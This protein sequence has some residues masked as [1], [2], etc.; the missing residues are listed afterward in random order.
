MAIKHIGVEVRISKRTMWVG[1]KVYPLAHVTRVEPLEIVPRRGRIVVRYARVAGAWLGLGILGLIV[2]TCAGN[3]VPPA[4]I[5]TYELVIV[6]GMIA[7][8]VRGIIRLTKSTLYVLSIATSGAPHE[9]VASWDR[10]QIYH[11]LNQ[12]VAAID[13]PNVDYT[14]H[15]DHIEVSGDAVFGPKIGD[16]VQGNKYT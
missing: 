14:V 16:S 1:S 11:L 4:L 12:V 13:D 10:D 9:V 6:A 5:L 3:S 8:V 7:T 15:I 2:L